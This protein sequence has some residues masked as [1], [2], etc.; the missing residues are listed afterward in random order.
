L[1]QVINKLAHL[2]VTHFTGSGAS[3]EQVGVWVLILL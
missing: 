3:F 1:I 2:G